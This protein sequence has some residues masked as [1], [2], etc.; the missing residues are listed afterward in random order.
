MKRWGTE[1]FYGSEIISY[2]SIVVDTCH[3]TFVKTIECTTARVV[4][5]SGDNDV[6]RVGSS[7]TTNTPM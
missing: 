3:Y 4:Q 1:H 2:D 7:V 6:F 5:V